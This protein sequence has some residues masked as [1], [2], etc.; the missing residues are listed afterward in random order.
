M[1]GRGRCL[2]PGRRMWAWGV[3]WSSTAEALGCTGALGG[4]EERQRGHIKV[5]ERGKSPDIRRRGRWGGEV[6][7]CGG[8]GGGRRHGWRWE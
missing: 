6:G 8:G 3:R 7:G 4:M 5:E 2:A 1:S